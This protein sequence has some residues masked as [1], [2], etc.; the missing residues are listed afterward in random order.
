M[1][2]NYGSSQGRVVWRS[3]TGLSVSWVLVLGVLLSWKCVYAN[4]EESATVPMGDFADFTNVTVAADSQSPG[5]ENL[6]SSAIVES[7]GAESKP[8]HAG[9]ESSDAARLDISKGEQYSQLDLAGSQ[10]MRSLDIVDTGS[11]VEFPAAVGGL[12]GGIDDQKTTVDPGIQPV[13]VS[14]DMIDQGDQPLVAGTNVVSVTNA[15]D[16]HG[17]VG[18]AGSHQLEDVSNDAVSEESAG[19]PYAVVLALLALIGLV[20]VARRDDH[21]HQV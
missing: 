13:T 18:D 4:A 16:A 20:P 21:H 19:L 1:R 14:N 10:D 15:A 5:V 11:S 6:D 8:I 9:P 7:T 17:H 3:L 12:D 2:D